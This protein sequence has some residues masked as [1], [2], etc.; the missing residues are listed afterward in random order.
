MYRTAI[1]MKIL[2]DEK[3]LRQADFVREAGVSRTQVHRHFK[4][5]LEPTLDERR[6]YARLAGMTFDEFESLWQN[7]RTVVFLKAFLTRDDHEA[8]NLLAAID[9]EGLRKLG[10]L[11]NQAKS[12][13]SKGGRAARQAFKLT[14]R[15]GDEMKSAARR[16]NPKPPP[17]GDPPPAPKG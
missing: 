15:A 7:D 10:S 3:G 17:P 4:G 6:R 11:V 2:M 16:K 1:A 8:I 12:A 14:P 5:D 13:A 9:I